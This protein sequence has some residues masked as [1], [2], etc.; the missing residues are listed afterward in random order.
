VVA[1]LTRS[2]GQ[3]GGRKGSIRSPFPGEGAT[4]R[5]YQPGHKLLQACAT[6]NRVGDAVYRQLAARDH[7]LNSGADETRGC[8]VIVIETERLLLREWCDEDRAPFAAMSVDPAVMKFLRILPTRAESDQ[9]IDYQIAHQAK[10][11][12]CLWAVENGATGTF[13]GAVGLLRV[14]FDAPFMP[15][16]E[17]GWRLA[18]A[19]WGRGIATEAARAALGFGFDRLG[20]D[21]IVAYAATANQASQNVM[22][23][24]GMARDASSDFDHPRVAPDSPL[25]RQAFY[26]IARPKDAPAGATSPAA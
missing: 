15:A 1:L 6:V 8:R 23:K 17:I 9:W 14:N 18:R 19:G 2:L 10:H 13:L 25:R 12:F 22:R 3:R 24:L 4:G 11:G 7:Q 26:R 16:V 20:L 5:S 21:E